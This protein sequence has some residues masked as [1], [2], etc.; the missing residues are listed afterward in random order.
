MQTLI[1][2][3][4]QIVTLRGLPLKGALSDGALEV[5]VDGGVVI[6]HGYIMAVGNFEK[7]RSTFLTVE[8]ELITSPAVLLPGFVDCHTHICFG[9]SRAMDYAMRIAG[10]PYLEIAQA[11]GGIWS[12]VKMTREAT[13]ELLLQT[14]LQRIRKHQTEGIT[15]IEI[16]SGYGLSTESELKML[17]VIQQASKICNADIV[18]TCLAAHMKPKDFNGDESAYLMEVLENLLPIV[19]KENLAE[20]VDIFIEKTAFS[21]G[22]AID[23]LIAAQK[24]GFDISVHADQF[25][26]GGSKVAIECGAIS[27]DH[28]EASTLKE[29]AALAASPTVAVVLPGASIGLGMQFAPARKLLDA[30][31]CVAIASDWNPGSAPQ[32]DLLMQAAVLGTFEKLNTAETFAGL[33]FRAA[34]AL[35]LTDRGTIDLGKKAHLQ[36]YPTSDYRDILYNQGK[37]KPY[38]VWM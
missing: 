16:K 38:K 11:G 15:T 12:S 2:P 17:R 24:L 20:R 37:L 30:G 8:V 36:A 7:L 21:E 33:C 23:Y 31:A 27:A 4:S 34:H 32:G 1:G 6:D 22:A 13:S 3:F 26:T 25:T 28:L 9:G 18:P 35:R 19:K 10:K 5:I 14:L 29:I